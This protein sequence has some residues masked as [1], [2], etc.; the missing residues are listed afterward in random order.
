MVQNNKDIV[1]FCFKDWIDLDIYLK[2]NI[3]KMYNF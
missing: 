1:F 2:Y 3:G